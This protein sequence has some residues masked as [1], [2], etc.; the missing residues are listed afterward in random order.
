MPQSFEAIRNI[1]CVGRNYALHAKELGNEA[2]GE[3]MIFGKPTHALSPASGTLLL[4]GHI[5]EIHYEI[6]LVVKIAAAYQKGMPLEQLI[7]GIALGID[8]TARDVQTKLKE[9]GHPWLLAKGF[10]GSA[11]LTGFLPFAEFS[12]LEQLEFSLI[13]NGEAVQ[14]GSPK[15]MLFPI[16]KLTDYI[17]TRLG[18]GAG[19]IIFTGI[20]EG[21]GPVASGDRFELLLNDSAGG[22]EE[23]FGPLLVELAADSANR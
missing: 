12:S 19:D 8:W 15:D 7:G 23:R 21:V 1:Y 11:V 5:G 22:R 9:K 3:P 14:T 20:P 13:K 6:E 17:G 4:P 2:P 16:G 10:I 18:L